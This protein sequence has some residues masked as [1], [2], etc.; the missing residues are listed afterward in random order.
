MKKK[1]GKVKQFESNGNLEFEGEYFN[2][3]KKGKEY[4][5]DGQII[6]EGEYL[7]GKRWKGKGKEF[8]I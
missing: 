1:N 2:G 3:E 6:F 7:E 5:K 8:E 4:N